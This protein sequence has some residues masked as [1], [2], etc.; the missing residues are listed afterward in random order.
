MCGHGAIGLVATLAHLNK[1]A[2]GDAPDRNTRRHRHRDLARG[3]RG[4]R[5]ERS[6]LAREEKCRRPNSRNR[7]GVWR[8]RVGR[9]LVFSGRRPWPRAFARARGHPHRFLLAGPP[10]VNAQG[11][12]EVDHVELFGPPALPGADSRNFVQC[13]GKAHDRSPCGTGTS[14]KLACLAADG[15]LPEGAVWVQESIIGSRFRGTFRWFDRAG[16]KSCHSSEATPFVNG[17]PPV[18]GRARS[19]LLGN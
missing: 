5:R 12:P 11:F 16:G 9:Q 14:A 13:P 10:G 7:G 4:L 3:R 6:E 15:K 17:S 8:H 19:L 1:I 2:P 18:A